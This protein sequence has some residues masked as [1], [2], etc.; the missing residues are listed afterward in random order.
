QHPEIDIHFTIGGRY[1]EL[2]AQI[3]EL[4]QKLEFIDEREVSF[5]EAADAWYELVYLPSVQILRQSGLI[6]A[7]PGRTEADLFAWM[8]LH[9]EKLRETYGDFENLSGLA[10]SLMETYKEKPATR[11]TRRVRSLFGGTELPRLEGLDD[12]ATDEE[13]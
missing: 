12:D 8:S 9:R 5:E 3:E 1:P 7:F 11:M 2:Q 10:Q 6:E 4:R 13:E